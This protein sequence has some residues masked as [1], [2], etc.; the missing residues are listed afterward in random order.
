MQC[1]RVDSPH[2]VICSLLTTLVLDWGASWFGPVASRFG[3]NPTVD[4]RKEHV[5]EKIH[6]RW[7]IMGV[8]KISAASYGGHVSGDWWMYIS[9]ASFHFRCY[10]G[11]QLLLDGKNI[12]RG[13]RFIIIVP[14]SVIFMIS[15][16]NFDFYKPI[17]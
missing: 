16:I 17:I 2:E 9:S 14:V 11:G 6:L 1:V 4:Q 10:G 15:L 3:W 5:G 13:Y 8:K 12:E 7:I